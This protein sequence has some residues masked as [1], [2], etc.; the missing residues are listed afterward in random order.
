MITTGAVGKPLGDAVSGLRIVTVNGK[1]LDQ[2]FY[3]L[4]ELPNQFPPAK[5]NQ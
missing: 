3:S 1:T 2:K 5:E 4:A